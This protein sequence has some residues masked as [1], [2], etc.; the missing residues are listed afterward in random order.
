MEMEGQVVEEQVT[1]QD[2]NPERVFLEKAI[3][4]ALDIIPIQIM[5]QAVVV[6]QEALELMVLLLL[7]A[8]VVAGQIVLLLGVV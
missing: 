6:V 1:V 3:M 8:T 7:A 4:V 2:T 5:V